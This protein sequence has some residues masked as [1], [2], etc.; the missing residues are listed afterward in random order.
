MQKSS[1]CCNN[2]T[3][4]SAGASRPEFSEDVKMQ[5]LDGIGLDNDIVISIVDGEYE[6]VDSHRNPVHSAYYLPAAEGWPVIDI[7]KNH[8]PI[9]FE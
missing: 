5:E 9:R 2:L 7:V 8:V 3:R 1:I 6:I 4:F